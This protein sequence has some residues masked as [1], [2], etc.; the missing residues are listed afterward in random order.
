MITFAQR[1]FDPRLDA[2]GATLT[3]YTPGSPLGPGEEYYKL[4]IARWYDVHEAQGKHHILVDVWDRDGRRASGVP[5]HLINGGDA[6][7]YTEPKY[8]EP[9]AV[10]LPMYSAGHPYSVR[11]GDASD[12][13]GG[14]GL[15]TIE[16][17]DVAHHTSYFLVFQ[18]TLE[19]LPPPLPGLTSDLMAVRDRFVRDI[20]A[21][22]ARYGSAQG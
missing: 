11:V 6:V 15:G 3:E 20:D 13:V 2:R 5:V 10:G 19:T 4:V 12:I 21:L 18:A 17:P 1:G 14:L 22:I 7:L 16:Q 8:G 9:A